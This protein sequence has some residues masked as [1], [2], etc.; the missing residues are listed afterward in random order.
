MYTH[1]IN[2]L[3]NGLNDAAFWLLKDGLAAAA[4]AVRYFALELV[5]L[6]CVYVGDE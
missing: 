6:L 3:D 1:C 2:S 5:V 4:A